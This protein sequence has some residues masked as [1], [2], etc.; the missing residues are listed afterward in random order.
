MTIST[1]D[2]NSYHSQVQ[3]LPIKTRTLS[4]WRKRESD[5]NFEAGSQA[6]VNDVRC[7][8]GCDT[9]KA[10]ISCHLAFYSRRNFTISEWIRDKLWDCNNFMSGAIIIQ[11]SFGW[12]H[13][14]LNL[15]ITNIILCQIY[16]KNIIMIL[17]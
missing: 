17:Q 14:Y 2:T 4:E 10:E 11:F 16:F 9:H 1:F 8:R 5:V 3:L 7:K 12:K 13:F 15:I 6:S